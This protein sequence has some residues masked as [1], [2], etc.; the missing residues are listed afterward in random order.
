M[1]ARAKLIQARISM[2]ALA[3]ERQ[4]ISWAGQ[5]VE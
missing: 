1:R 5:V 3:D 4:N 2:L